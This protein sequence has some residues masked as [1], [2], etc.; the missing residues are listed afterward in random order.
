LRGGEGRGLLRDEDG[1]DTAPVGA[2][3]V[4]LGVVPYH[5]GFAA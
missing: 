5:R 2:Q 3:Y 4:R 1:G